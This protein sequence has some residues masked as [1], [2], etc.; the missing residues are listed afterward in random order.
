MS[1]VRASHILLMYQGSARS[2][3]TR[4]KAEAEQ[5]INALAEQIRGGADFGDLAKA[6]SDCPSGAKGGDL[7]SFGK[8]Q[9]V[10]PFEV[11]AFGMDVGQVSGVIET[12]FG[13]HII[14]RTG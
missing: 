1:T 9:M 12:D 6:N 8:G 4:S 14:K 5:Q 13:Y 11:A 2:T 10:K 3:A 7:G